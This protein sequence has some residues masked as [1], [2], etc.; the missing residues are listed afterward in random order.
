MEWVVVVE[1][2]FD[3]H[4]L[5]A[6]EGSPLVS[7]LLAGGLSSS[8]LWCQHTPANMANYPVQPFSYTHILHVVGVRQCPYVSLLPL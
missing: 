7:G 6:G 4:C 3:C 8:L 5:G 2:S 1:E